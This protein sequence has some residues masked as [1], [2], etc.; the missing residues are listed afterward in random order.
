VPDLDPADDEVSGIESIAY[1]AEQ[2]IDTAGQLLAP[3]PASLGIEEIHEACAKR[4]ASYECF[5]R[6]HFVSDRTDELD[7][8]YIK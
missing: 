3:K 1:V 2:L 4:Q 5:G 8:W 6:P 7:A